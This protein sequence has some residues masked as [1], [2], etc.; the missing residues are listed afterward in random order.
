MLCEKAIISNHYTVDILL[1]DMSKVFDTINREKLMEYLRRLLQSDDLYF[2]G[3]QYCIRVGD[4]IRRAIQNK[5][6]VYQQYY[7]Y[8]TLRYPWKI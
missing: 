8:S 6:I 5:E 3:V 7:W 1:M 2:N 4:I